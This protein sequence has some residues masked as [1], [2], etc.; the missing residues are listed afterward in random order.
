M[1]TEAAYSEERRA[2][3]L[4]IYCE[5]GANEAARQ[6]GVAR[7]TI[8]RWAK[9]ADLATVPLEKVAAACEAAGIV[10]A[11][12]RLGEAT[13]AGVDAAEVRERMVGYV[14][15]GKTLDA[16]RLVSVYGVLI[17][18][19]QLLSGG[20][21]AREDRGFDWDADMLRLQRDLG[22]RPE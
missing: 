2:E 17:D 15:E 10:W 1:A 20:P 8:W 12:R 9:D 22:V 11:N 4:A 16:M 6:T 14:L 3:V 5:T 18:K 13:Q 19:A 7:G 21:T